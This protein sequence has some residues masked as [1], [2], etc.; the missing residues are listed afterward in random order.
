M[1]A[2]LTSVF[3]FG[4]DLA[5]KTTFLF[6]AAGVALLALRRRPASERHLI[7]TLALAA[8]L[9]F[10]LLAPIVPRFE[11][12][13]LPAPS[14]RSDLRVAAEAERPAPE[15]FAAVEER[16]AFEGETSEELLGAPEGEPAPV[17]GDLD[18]PVPAK[19]EM[20]SR[21]ELPMAAIA[22]AVVLWIAVALAL[23]ARLAVGALRVRKLRLSAEPV[24]D[25]EWRDLADSLRPA[26]STRRSVALF[27][28]AH[29]PVAVTSGLRRPVLLLPESAQRWDAPRRRVVL[30]HELAHVAR[31]DWPALLLAE[32]AVAVYWFH[33]LTW[34]LARRL[35]REAERAADDRV[36][37]AGTKPSVYAGHLLG[38]FR[39]LVPSSGEPL[40][41]MGMA[42]PSH[43]EER[44]RSILDPALGRRGVTT[45][46]AKGAAVVFLAAAASLAVLQPWSARCAE[47]A[48]PSEFPQAQTLPEAAVM[49]TE[50]PA[51]PAAAGR[52]HRCPRSLESKPR[53]PAP[54]PAAHRTILAVNDER[55][56]GEV[57]PV[58]SE[59]PEAPETPA[60]AAFAL[61]SPPT[62]FL[63]AGNHS[64][65]DGKEAYRL[66]WK[67]HEEERWAEASEAFVRAY[68]AGY[69]KDVSAYN[70]ACGF[71]REGRKDAAFEWLEKA[72]VEGFDV[73]SY[74]SRDEDL[75]SLR[76]DERFQDLRQRL[77]HA[78]LVE[79]QDEVARLSERLRALA[80][81][82]PRRS[83][84][85]YGLGKELLDVGSYELAAQAFC[86]SARAGVRVDAS[87]YNTACAYALSGEKD[88]ALDY[89]KQALEAGFD[90]SRLLEKDTD[91]DSVRSDPRF[92]DL[93]ELSEALKLE[94]G[95]WSH[96]WKKASTG[97]REN[98]KKAA[99]NYETV[100]ARHPEFGRAW[101]NLGFARL[102]AG[103][104]AGS[105]VAYEKALG[106]R[107]REPTTLYNLACANAQ[108][109]K[110]DEA[111][112]YLFQAL[113]RGFGNR[114]ILR[115]DDDL[116]PLRGD[117]RF[118]EALKLAQKSKGEEF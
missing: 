50:S 26:I 45:L 85:L 32:V 83:D 60:P 21:F 80:E 90:D 115:A 114:L 30:L 2:T 72:A 6:A 66:G 105:A 41:V 71:A 3:R 36:L 31:R 89:L 108:M 117:P 5:L 38:I 23:L 14:P 57:A 59:A 1:D 51:A 8:A 49:E 109:G 79:K 97:E 53:P 76:P 22:G 92:R 81:S 63:P 100:A 99:R 94:P 87:L 104:A 18:A 70:A 65:R 16:R 58:A 64:S 12:P 98:R 96:G 68:A 93:A 107:Y 9:A 55:P 25:A 48:L 52:A 17:A 74:L 67:R 112:G 27:W 103:D 11:L 106:L 19:P 13:L 77:R 116:D 46:Q 44:L 35:R 54:I 73:L 4:L 7:G 91:L 88:R 24:R 111:F 78:S 47:A 28:S 75:E 42:R 15:P 101:F 102:A 113:H 56:A 82:F 10:P 34:I 43:F 61:K 110:K 40:P 33:P 95:D 62:G 69:K 37:A 20:R 84:E 86:L 118:H 29:V 39:S